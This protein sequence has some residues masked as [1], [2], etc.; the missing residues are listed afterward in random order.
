MNEVP[1][2]PA[3]ETLYLARSGENIDDSIALLSQEPA[4][5]LE[6]DSKA[7]VLAYESELLTGRMQTTDGRQLQVEHA[8][9]KT[10]P[11]IVHGYKYK[12]RRHEITADFLLT[13]AGLELLGEHRPVNPLN[14]VEEAATFIRSRALVMEA[15]KLKT[16]AKKSEA[17]A[18]EKIKQALLTGQEMADPT[19]VFV[20]ED[21]TQVMQRASGLL[22]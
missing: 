1:A 18:S 10:L 17:F 9:D 7:E 21:V 3:Q 16:I 11:E 20:F 6:P 14:N 5:P 19:R 13:D 2:M 12:N 4:M 15:D 22:A 8:E